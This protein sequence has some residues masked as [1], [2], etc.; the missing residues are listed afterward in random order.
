MYVVGI[1]DN[2]NTANHFIQETTIS[3]QA[4]PRLSAH[5]P[6]TDG[7]VYWDA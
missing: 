6:W 7:S 4:C 3:N 5:I 2:I 1:Q